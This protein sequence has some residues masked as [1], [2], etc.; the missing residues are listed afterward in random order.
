MDSVKFHLSVVHVELS[1]TKPA[2]AVLSKD[3]KMKGY[4]SG[5]MGG[6]WTSKVQMRVLVEN[7]ALLI[8]N[9]LMDVRT[10]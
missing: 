9:V 6:V 5:P 7:A 2:P 10:A 8:H 4:V 3:V 1:P